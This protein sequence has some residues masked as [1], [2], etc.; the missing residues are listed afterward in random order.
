MD[1]NV[2]TFLLFW[3]F[4]GFSARIFVAFSMFYPLRQCM[5]NI[6]LIAR[7][8]GFLWFYPGVHSL[9]VPYFDTNDFYYSGHIGATFIVVLEYWRLGWPWMAR[10][11]LFV[12]VNEWFL[13]MIVRSH[14]IIDFISGIIVAH[15]LHRYAEKIS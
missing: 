1:L 12:M 9:T 15:Y 11:G 3:Y 7:M 10:W 5:Q 6:F 8:E 13:L 4:Y 14:Y 2:V